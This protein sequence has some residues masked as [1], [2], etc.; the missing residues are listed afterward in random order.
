MKII[1]SVKPKYA[2]KI[3]EG[4]KT[5]ELRKTLFKNP[6]INKV[7]VYASSPIS[8]IIGEFEIEEIIHLELNEL[9]KIVKD[10]S[11]VDKKFYDEY[12]Q[13]R[14]K[15]YAIGIKNVKKYINYIDIFE[16]FGIKAPQSFAYIK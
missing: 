14:E 12:F 16:E 11:E 4:K 13:N 15:G 6:E 1:L 7:L 9:W 8:K 2:L 5:Y 3:L 10:K